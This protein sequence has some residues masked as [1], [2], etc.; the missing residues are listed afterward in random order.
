[1]EQRASPVYASKA[2]KISAAIEGAIFLTGFMGTGKTRIGR[3]LA[4][5]MRRT[6]LDTDRLVEE[7]AGQTISEIF[8]AEGEDLFRQLE[9]DCVSQAAARTDAVI[10][11]GGGAIADERN[12]EVIRRAGVVVALE[13]SV[14]TILKRVSQRN[15]R[16]LLA[17]LSR[18]E[19]RA[20]I[21]ELLAARAPYYGRAHIHLKT[22][23][24]QTPEA[25][26]GELIRL[27]ERWC[28][29]R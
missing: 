12:W 11:L 3:V 19:K 17:G 27:M 25:T 9:H 14:D 2:K 18:E 7:S 28:E 10:A 4:T 8:T 21:A 13:A 1:M 16:P 15:D 29:D 5:R 23:D 6:F 26:A 22:L 20:R 24:K